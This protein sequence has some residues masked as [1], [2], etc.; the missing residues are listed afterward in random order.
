MHLGDVRRSMLTTMVDE[1][2]TAE[3]ERFATA[4]RDANLDVKRATA[5]L[6]ER[7]DGERVTRVAL[8]LNEPADDTWDIDSVREL[9]QAL[10][11]KAT[12]LDLPPVS[13][14]LVPESEAELVEAF[15]D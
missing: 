13:V 6:D 10:G 2:A 12:E 14:T 9:K 8:L 1:A 4:Y 5:A 11:R 3:L 15:G 7:R